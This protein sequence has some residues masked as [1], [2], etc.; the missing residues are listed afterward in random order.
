VREAQHNRS[1]FECRVL[2][3][4][5]PPR[6]GDSSHHAPRDEPLEERPLF[7]RRKHDAQ[8]FSPVPLRGTITRSVMTTIPSDCGVLRWEFQLS[9]HKALAS[10]RA[11]G[12][13]ISNS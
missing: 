1:A 8:R 7:A 2:V 6:S 9:L 10:E 5:D 11:S 13:E 12:W 3:H 4:R